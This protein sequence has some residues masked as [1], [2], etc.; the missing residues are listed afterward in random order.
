[1]KTEASFGHFLNS[2]LLGY[3]LKYD[4]IHSAHR[5]CPIGTVM[6]MKNDRAFAVPDNAQR[7]YQLTECA[8]IF[9]R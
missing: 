8:F 6:T 1:M 9:S 3:S 5:P 4:T 7:F 2:L